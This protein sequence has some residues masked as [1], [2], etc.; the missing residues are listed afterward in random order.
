MENFTTKIIL[1]LLIPFSIL[2]GVG[3]LFLLIGLNIPP[4]TKYQIV[5]TAFQIYASLIALSVFVI[6]PPA[7]LV[8]GGVVFAV[9]GF[10]LWMLE[11]VRTNY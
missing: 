2:G 10:N 6:A 8:F 3:L 4:L 1:T 7:S 11:Y 9:T 5:L